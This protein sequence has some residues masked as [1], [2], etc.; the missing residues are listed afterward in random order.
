MRLRQIILGV[1]LA[2]LVALALLFFS[3]A[4]HAQP[5]QNVAVVP[6][7]QIYMSTTVAALPVNSVSWDNRSRGCDRWV[8]TYTTYGFAG[9]LS[10]AVQSSADNVGTPAGWV[11]FAGTVV[12]GINPNT[13]ANQALS[14]FSGFYPWMKITLTATGVGAG[15][16]TATLYGYRDRPMS[17]SVGG[18]AGT[19]LSQYGGV[20]V[21]A[22]NALH[23]QP[24]TAAYFPPSAVAAVADGL[25][26][27]ASLGSG[28]L[29][30]FPYVYDA[31]GTW[32]RMRG[33]SYGIRV[34]GNSAVGAAVLQNPVI[35]GGYGS[36]IAGGHA[37][38]ISV[39]DSSAPITLAAAAG[40]TQIVALAAGKSIRICHVSV[41]FAGAETASL[42]YGTDANCATGTTAMTGAYPNILALALDFPQSPLVAASAKAVC[43]RQ[44]TGVG[45][46]GVVTYALY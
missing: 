4:L 2:V 12:S 17:V 41:G 39:C 22:G 1:P 33:S 7:C 38:G 30:V 26:S 45:G 43:V 19:N 10:L 14:S 32:N 35:V 9:P 25:A 44:I 16:V 8:V 28:P 6:E 42:A 27:N 40:Y 31:G 34:E 23:I 3:G 21:G 46:G 29:A 15:R 13:A 24:G 5:V 36:G 37:A 11:N 18:V 20:A